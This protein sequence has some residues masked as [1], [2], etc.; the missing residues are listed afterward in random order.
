VTK[1]IQ[2]I[3]KRRT[4]DGQHPQSPTEI[5]AWFEQTARAWNQQPAPSSGTASAGNGGANAPAI[6]T[7]SAARRLTRGSRF[8]PTEAAARNGRS[9]GK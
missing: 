6:D 9:R 8:Q 7:P 4:L 5:G 3:L 2:R 1:P